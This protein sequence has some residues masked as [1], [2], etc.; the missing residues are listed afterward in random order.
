M[1]NFVGWDHENKTA[2]IIDLQQLF[3]KADEDFSILSKLMST[4]LDL[5]KAYETT[6]DFKADVTFNVPGE[7][8][9]TKI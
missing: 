3:A 6:G 4:N 9:E 1:G 7:P 8:S 2:I 5:D